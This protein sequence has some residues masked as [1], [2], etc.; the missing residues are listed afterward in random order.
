MNVRQPADMWN[1]TNMGFRLVKLPPQMVKTLTK[2]WKD[3]KGK[4][5]EDAWF[6]GNTYANHGEAPTAMLDV[7]D[8]KLKGGGEKLVDLIWGHDST[9]AGGM[10]RAG[11]DQDFSLR[12]SKVHHQFC[13][14]TARGS[15]APGDEHGDQC[16]PRREKAVDHGTVG[17]RRKSLQCH[18][19]GGG[20]AH[21]RESQRGS[22][23]ALAAQGQVLCQSGSMMRWDEVRTMSFVL[24]R[25]VYDS[26]TAW[27][28]SR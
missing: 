20:Y 3:N 26:R 25:I 7:S 12:N 17:T 1:Y 16:G 24:L 5:V 19:G 18:H 23:E 13:I 21:V 2:F 28:H 9:H 27:M 8:S 11:T 10:D 4:E 6:E 15:N 14:G 22:W